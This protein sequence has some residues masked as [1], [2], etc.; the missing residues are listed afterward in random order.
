LFAAMS[1]RAGA[2]FI[3]FN[4]ARTSGV[5]HAPGLGLRGALNGSAILERRPSYF[6]AICDLLDRPSRAR[7]NRLISVVFCGREEC[8][9]EQSYELRFQRL[10]KVSADNH[11]R[12]A[13]VW[14]LREA[15]RMAEAATLRCPEPIHPA[16]V[17]PAPGNELRA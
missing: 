8:N 3:S 16:V 4:R 15:V 10:L 2:T 17:A 11:K 13:E 1:A 12:M 5:P 14:A 9:M 7:K 6:L